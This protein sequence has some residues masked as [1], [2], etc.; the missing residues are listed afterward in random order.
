MAEP[1]AAPGPVMQLHEMQLCHRHGLTIHHD[2]FRWRR[3]RHGELYFAESARREARR[4]QR[5]RG[6]PA[7]LGEKP[8]LPHRGRHSER[9]AEGFAS[10]TERVTVPRT[11]S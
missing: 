10:L 6:D 11:A 9:L 3:D 4:G 7:I 5:F 8:P 2:G 1:D